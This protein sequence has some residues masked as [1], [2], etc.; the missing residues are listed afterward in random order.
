LELIKAKSPRTLV[1]SY[2]ND[3]PFSSRYSR[4]YW[5]RHLKSVT[6]YDLVYAYRPSNIQQYRAAGAKKVKLLP[7]WFVKHRTFPTTLGQ[8][9]LVKYKSDVVLV[10]HYENDGRLELVKSLIEAGI[11]VSLYGPEWNDVILKDPLLKNYYPV[12]YLSDNEYRK[13]LCGSKIA[14]AIY[15]SLNSDVYTRKCFEIPATRTMM[16]AKRTEEMLELFT[17]DVECVFFDDIEELIDKINIYL[18]QNDLRNKIAENGY[19]RVISSGH[20][21]IGRAA[22]ILESF[23]TSC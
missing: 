6:S 5:A 7:P 9:E 21:A 22:Y 10:A 19:K 18:R 23:K 11:D 13:A 16:I 3:N 20:D 12:T 8:S 15:S 1:V 4:Y 17:E 14:L 2:N